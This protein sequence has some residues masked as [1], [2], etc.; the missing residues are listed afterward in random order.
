VPWCVNFDLDSFYRVQHD[1]FMAR[2]ARQDGGHD[3]RVLKLV[4]AYLKAGVTAD[5]QP[6]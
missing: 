2:G 3:K 4:R 1:A 5:G 6:V